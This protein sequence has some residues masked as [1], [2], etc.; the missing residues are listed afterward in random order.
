MDQ[1]WVD[2]L[3]SRIFT[4]LIGPNEE[5]FA[6][7]ASVLEK[8]SRPLNV[9]LTGG[10][11]EAQEGRVYW[12][13]IDAPIFGR[14]MQWVYT[15]NYDT[16]EPTVI[17]TAEPELELAGL[18]ASTTP[19]IE[20]RRGTKCTKCNGTDVYRTSGVWPDPGGST[21]TWFICGCR[22][23]STRGY[24]PRFRGLGRIE[25]S[26][27][28]GQAAR[29]EQLVEDF[30]S[31]TYPGPRRAPANE[32]NVRKNK[33]STEDYSDVLLCHAKLYVLGDKYL[34]PEL[35]QL[36]IHRLHA[37]LKV[38]VLYPSRLQD[39]VTLVRYTFVNV[40]P[41]DEICSMLSAYCACIVEQLDAQQGKELERLIKEVPDFALS[42]VRS[43]K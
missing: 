25:D 14:F 3:K 18:S 13:D 24:H 5:E 16:P 9:L 1:P 35:M 21:Q 7:H 27:R 22:T 41:D 30:G 40:H 29:M 17:T 34:I 19:R 12:P 38:F 33:D 26:T 2:I 6:V 37:T 31:K 42:L 39:I 43:L 23:C 8:A 32:F 4:F 36:A 11:K 28:E 10:L 20:P 15:Q